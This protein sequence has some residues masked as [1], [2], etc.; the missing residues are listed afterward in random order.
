[1]CICFAFSWVD[2][3]HS[4]NVGTKAGSSVIGRSAGSKAGSCRF[5]CSPPL[6]VTLLG[7]RRGVT[8]TIDYHKALEDVP[9][10]CLLV[11]SHEFVECIK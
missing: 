11:V 10:S 5:W 2:R 7:F 3:P 9:S 4:T 8:A 1:M 6:R